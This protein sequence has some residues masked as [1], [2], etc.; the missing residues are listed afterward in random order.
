M[1]QQRTQFLIPNPN[2]EEKEQSLN[3]DGKMEWTMILKLWEKETG[4]T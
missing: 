1:D 3:L 2:A 4:K